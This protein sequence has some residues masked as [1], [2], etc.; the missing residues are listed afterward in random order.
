MPPADPILVVIEDEPGML[1]LVD[2]AVQSTGFRTI[3]HTS[4][5]EAR[6]C[7]S[8]EPADVALVDLQMAELGGLDVLRE[9][10]EAQPQCGV[11]LMAAHGS[12]DTAIDAVKLGA[13]DYLTRPID[14]ERLQQ[15]LAGAREDARRRAELLVTENATAHRME[16][17][18]IIGRSAVMQQL[19]GLVRRIAP[20]ARTAMITGEAGAGKRGVASAIHALGPRRNGR[21]VAFDCS[22]GL[23]MPLE[24]ALFGHVRGALDHEAGLFETMD[25]GTV[26]LEEVGDLPPESQTRLM[27]VLESGETHRIGSLHRQKVDVAMVAASSRDLRVDVHAGRFRSDLYQR[28]NVVHLHVPPLRERRE[29]IPYLTAAFV[30]EFAARFGKA[31]AEVTPGAERILMTGHWRGNVGELRSVLERACALAEGRV[32][33]E[34]DVEAAM[35]AVREMWTPAPPTPSAAPLGLD[36]LERE[37]IIR[38]LREVRGN[39]RVAAQRLGISRRTLYR[40]LE[41]H[42]LMR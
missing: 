8:S 28:L 7:L 9:I 1:A 17:C 4:A 22:A 33:T 20:H 2:R 27:R 41:R 15:L 30:Q 39:K 12:I 13:L 23:E 42:G 10:H 26:F 34:R 37:H 25:G 36:A 16:L 11:I 40:R 21:F 19:F 38:V 18:G 24:S 3:M 35:P 14:V 32:L 5:R 6:D 29:D 31:L